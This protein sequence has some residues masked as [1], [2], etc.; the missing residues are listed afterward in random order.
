[1]ANNCFHF[2]TFSIVN[3]NKTSVF[4]LNQL[5]F[6]VSIKDLSYGGFLFSRRES[7]TLRL[8]TTS[9]SSKEISLSVRFSYLNNLIN[10]TCYERPVSLHPFSRVYF[11]FF[12][13]RYVKY[14][15]F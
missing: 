1:M 14:E 6:S 15:I 7:M 13:G 12:F 11:F 4:T 3:I 8:V 9:H 2:R 10:N 5:D